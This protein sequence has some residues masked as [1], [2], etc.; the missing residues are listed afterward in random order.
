M[1]G[2]LHSFCVKLIRCHRAI[3][4]LRADNKAGL[5]WVLVLIYAD[6]TVY[7]YLL[8]EHYIDKSPRP[9]AALII[10]VC[11]SVHSRSVAEAKH[12]DALPF[13]AV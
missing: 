10:C 12:K 8:V 5:V 4:I 7:R 13:S 6:Y 2:Q 3:V 11:D 9:F 1:H